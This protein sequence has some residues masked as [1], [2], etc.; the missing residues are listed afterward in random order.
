MH[1]AEHSFFESY[2]AAETFHGVVILALAVLGVSDPGAAPQGIG[3]VRAQSF[4][5]GFSRTSQNYFGVAIRALLHQEIAD[6]MLDVG[7]LGGITLAI[8]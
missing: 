2:D 4:L 5:T 6:G 8:G 7:P 3:I 1:G